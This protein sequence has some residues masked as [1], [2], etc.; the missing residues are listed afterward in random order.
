MICISTAVYQAL[1][2]DA[3]SA[4]SQILLLELQYS[5]HH[6]DENLGD[7]KRCQRQGDRWP[8]TNI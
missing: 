6:T 3:R 4:R 1:Q 7:W 2:K 8:R 5:V